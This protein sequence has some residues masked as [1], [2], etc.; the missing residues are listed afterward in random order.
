MRPADEQ[1]ALKDEF[2]PGKKSAD[3]TARGFRFMHHNA[4][5]KEFSGQGD[6]SQ[7]PAAAMEAETAP[8]EKS[9]KQMLTLAV[10]DVDKAAARVED[11]IKEYGGKIL[12]KE[13]ADNAMSLIVNVDAAS[14]NRF[15]DKLKT[16]GEL[17]GIDA[18]GIRREGTI[19]EIRI[20]KQV[21]P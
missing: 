4:P 15:T 20:V 19:I 1:R 6:T 8:A 16:L 10:S 11:T 3:Q 21:Q 7:A 2:S 12:R 14:R 9:G 13:P 18:A 5:E 17:K